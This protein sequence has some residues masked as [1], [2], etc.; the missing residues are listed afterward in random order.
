PPR[1]WSLRKTRA[2]SSWCAMT[3]SLLFCGCRVGT[4]SG[5]LIGIAVP[6]HE[7]GIH[8]TSSHPPRPSA[9]GSL[10][11]AS[12]PCGTTWLAS[13]RP[14]PLRCSEGGGSPERGEWVLAG[15]S[16]LPHCCEGRAV[17]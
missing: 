10:G 12:E 14:G 15:T 6:Y 4:S 16:Q 9:T 2:V 5:L 8:T 17:P 3:N 11:A 13:G 1:R 7:Y